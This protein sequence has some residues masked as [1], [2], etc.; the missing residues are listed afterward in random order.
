LA[1]AFVDRWSRI[2][3]FVFVAGAVL[4]VLAAVF[5]MWVGLHLWLGFSLGV[6]ARVEHSLPSW[7]V[8][9]V[10]IAFGL[11]AA[12]L[13][14]RWE[15]SGATGRWRWMAVVAVPFWAM[16]WIAWLAGVLLFV[17]ALI[18]FLPLFPF[19]KWGEKRR[20]EVAR[21]KYKAYRERQERSERERLEFRAALRREMQEKLAAKRKWQ[22]EAPLRAEQRRLRNNERRRA[23]RAAEKEAQRVR[24]VDEAMKDELYADIYRTEGF[25]SRG[26]RTREVKLRV[27]VETQVSPPSITLPLGDYV[28]YAEASDGEGEQNLVLVMLFLDEAT[29][30]RLGLSEQQRPVKFEVL[31]HVKSGA[32]QLVED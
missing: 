4:V 1:T 19:S 7:L 11:T 30:G 25:R 10:A 9:T 23:R 21:E 5:G 8:P 22:A 29:I 31:R 13:M 6:V 18:P 3:A 14:L 26:S 12:L 20:T 24:E 28:G 27:T 15:L 16:Q 17:L 2:K 32:I